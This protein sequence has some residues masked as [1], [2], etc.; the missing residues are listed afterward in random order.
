VRGDPLALQP[1]CHAKA[2]KAQR[3]K[4]Y[5]LLIVVKGALTVSQ[6]EIPLSVEWVKRM[7]LIL[8]GKIAMHDADLVDLYEVKTDGFVKSPSAAL[9][10]TFVVAA[11]PVSTL[12]SS[13]FARLASG[14]FYIAIQIMTFYESIKTKALNQA[15]KR[16]ERQFAPDIMFRLTKEEKKNWSQIVPG[17]KP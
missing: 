10:F 16:N 8:R 11:Y 2:Q 7:I 14:A 6:L 12:H 4:C 17:S 5:A 15:L 1:K 9:R 3:R 13:C